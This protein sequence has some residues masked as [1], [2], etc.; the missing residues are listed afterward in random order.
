MAQ[1]TF[2]IRGALRPQ[3]LGI[4][5]GLPATKLHIW[6]V[7]QSPRCD[8][9]GIDATGERRTQ[10]PPDTLVTAHAIW[11]IAKI[12]ANNHHS[13][14]TDVLLV[15]DQGREQPPQSLHAIWARLGEGTPVVCGLQ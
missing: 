14:M 8:A 6:I 1:C 9:D 12:R 4:I 3:Y 5:N 10:L 15:V 13:P 2:P 7:T 11:L